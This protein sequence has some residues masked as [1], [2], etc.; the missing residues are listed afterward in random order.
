MAIH[1]RNNLHHR[2]TREGSKL[3]EGKGENGDGKDCLEESKY[4]VNHGK[5]WG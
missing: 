5:G 2:R 4:K 1:V 3:E